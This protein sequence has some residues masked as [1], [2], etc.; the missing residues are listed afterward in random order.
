MIFAPRS[1]MPSMTR[2]AVSSSG[3]FSAVSTLSLGN[4]FL[5]ACEPSYAAWLYPKSSL[6]PT[7]MNPTALLSLP[8]A[9][10]DDWADDVPAATTIE[11]MTIATRIARVIQR[12]RMCAPSGM[13]LGDGSGRWIWGMGIGRGWTMGSA[14]RRHL[15]DL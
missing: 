15:E 8:G 4:A 11:V 5:T 12:L 2:A 10:D 13:D 14:A 6:G 7:K 9:S 3:T 1:I